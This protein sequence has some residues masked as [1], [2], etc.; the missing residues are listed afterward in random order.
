MDERQKTGQEVENL[1]RERVKAA[2]G[3]YHRA[4]TEAEAALESCGYDST[5]AD[6]E[7]LRESIAR[8]SAALEEYMRVLRTF[9]DFI[10]R[11]PPTH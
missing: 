1:L 7:I 2:E 10:T 5:R 11:N 9:H 8:E 6:I 4:R 3:K